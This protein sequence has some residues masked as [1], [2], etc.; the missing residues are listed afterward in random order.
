MMEAKLLL[1]FPPTLNN[2]YKCNRRSGGKRISAEGLDYRIKLHNAVRDN[3]WDFGL[4]E[5]LHVTL[6]I[7]MP[8]NKTRDLDNYKKALFDACTES[9]VWKDDEQIDRDFT[10]RGDVI[11]GG[12]IEMIIQTAI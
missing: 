4:T 2:Y 10:F 1:P 6:V 8:D 7:N 3:D 12:S 11:P 5:R 9:G